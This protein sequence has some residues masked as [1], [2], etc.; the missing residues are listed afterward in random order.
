MI[1]YLCVI[2]VATQSE[3]T[4]TKMTVDLGIVHPHLLTKL[5]HIMHH[6]NH[7][8]QAHAQGHA[9]PIVVKARLHDHTVRLSLVGGSTLKAVVTR[10]SEAALFVDPGVRCTI[11]EQKRAT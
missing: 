10:V 3:S 7:N 8:H 4:K 6:N 11:G 1:A 5:P 9:G 2:F